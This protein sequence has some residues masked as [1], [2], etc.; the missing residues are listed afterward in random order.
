MWLVERYRNFCCTYC[1][2]T[3]QQ[4]KTKKSYFY[5]NFIWTI[6]KFN[7]TQIISRFDPDFDKTFFPFFNGLVAILNCRIEK[8]ATDI[9]Y[10][11][12]FKYYLKGTLKNRKWRRKKN[13]NCSMMSNTVKKANSIQLLKKRSISQAKI[14]EFSL[15]FIRCL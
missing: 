12:G 7:Y 11:P 8:S 13:W 10:R 4:R 1:R 2:T 15:N 9:I 3:V 6:A 5:P 14:Y